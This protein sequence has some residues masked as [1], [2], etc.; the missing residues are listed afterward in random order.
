MTWEPTD[1]RLVQF[2]DEH[3]ARVMAM[4]VGIVSDRHVAE[5]L[6]QETFLRVY[7]QW[8]RVQLMSSP[9]PWVTRVACNLANSWWRRR[10]A[11]HRAN[12]RHAGS[13]RGPTPAE[14]ADVLAVRAAVSALP[15]R[16]RTA[17]VMRYFGGLSV[18]DTAT[19]M[20][21]RTGTVKSL[22]HRATNA[23]RVA[24][25]ADPDVPVVDARPQSPIPMI[26]TE[27]V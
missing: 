22:T 1:E 4:I 3:Q 14:P 5:D 24:L 7:L 9:G 26:M 6:T 8:N 20:H 11:E 13:P 12:R 10:Y 25:D 21:C 2:C 27:E 23:L 19:A 15:P 18:E 17:I 16:Q